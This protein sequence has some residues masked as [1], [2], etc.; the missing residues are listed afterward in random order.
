MTSLV[1]HYFSH[2]GSLSPIDFLIFC[3]QSLAEDTKE[4]SKNDNGI[5]LIAIILMSLTV[6]ITP[7]HLENTKGLNLLFKEISAHVLL[8]LK[9]IVLYLL[10]RIWYHLSISLI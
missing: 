8:L 5:P 6:V 4:E 1:E 3:S 7:Q 10:T 2:V 9:S